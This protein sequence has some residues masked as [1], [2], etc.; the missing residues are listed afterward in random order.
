MF[1]SQGVQTLNRIRLAGAVFVATA[2][3]AS[4]ASAHPRQDAVFVQTDNPNGNTVVAYDRAPDG[5]LRQAGSYTTGGKGGVLDGSVVDHLASQGSLALD[6]DDLYAVNAGSNTITAFDVEGD[7][8]IRR[9]VL[10]SFGEFPV[11]VA[12]HGNVLYVLNARNGGSIQGYLRAG[13][14]LVPIPI[15]HRTLGLDPNAAP[16]F[17]HTPGQI[18][19]SPSGDQLLVTTKANTNA[20]DVF[21]VDRFLGPSLRPTVNALPGTVPFAVAFDARGDVALTEAGPNAVATFSLDRRGTLHPLASAPT[22]QA[23]TCWITFVNGHL[24]ASNAGSGNVSVFDQA[25]HPTATTAT[26]GGTVDSAASSD[27]RFLYVQGGAAGTVDAFRVAPNGTL[28]P[29]GTVTVPGAVGGEGIA[30]S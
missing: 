24:Y 12:V 1:I 26:S 4:S 8:L 27:G 18:A 10:P 22:G 29:A 28:T 6:G 5:S 30:A 17:T 9:Q 2:L 20:I 15:W 21:D 13:G 19:F 14:A 23:A 16:E 25:L 3:F 11:S 7:R